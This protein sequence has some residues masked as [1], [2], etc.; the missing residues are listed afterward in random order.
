M[1]SDNRVDLLQNLDPQVVE[2]LLPL[3]ARAERHDIAMLLSYPE[4]SAG[5]VMTTEYASLPANITASE[6][7]QRMRTK[8]RTAR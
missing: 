4:S 8:R 5:A 3:V 2:E 6:A 7:L 1:A